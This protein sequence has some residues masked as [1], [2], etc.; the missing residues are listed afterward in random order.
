MGVQIA[1]HAARAGDLELLRMLGFY[2]LAIA[3]VGVL[4][5]PKSPFW[6]ALL[7]GPVFI[8]AGFGWLA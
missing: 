1:L 7:L 8:G 5:L 2:L 3:L 6:A 4:A